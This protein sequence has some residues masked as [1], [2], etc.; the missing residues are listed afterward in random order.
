[1]TREWWRDTGQSGGGHPCPQAPHPSGGS[2][3]TPRFDFLMLAMGEMKVGDIQLG[4]I[5]DGQSSLPIIVRLR[6]GKE[7][8]LYFLGG[9]NWGY[10]SAYHLLEKATVLPF[11]NLQ[12]RPDWPRKVREMNWTVWYAFKQGQG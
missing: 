7:G 6:A 2:C 11:S 4:E 10:I 12:T 9:F 5:R 3:A 8:E 1:M